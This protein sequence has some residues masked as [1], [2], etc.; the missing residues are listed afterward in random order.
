MTAS[1][2][3]RSRLARLMTSPAVIW[4]V[5]TS[6][7]PLAYTLYDSFRDDRLL[8]PS[9]GFAGLRNY[10]NFVRNPMFAG[11]V[12]HSLI[13]TVGVVATTLALGTALALILD[14]PVKGRSAL[15]LLV[16][17]PFVTMPAVSA[18]VWKNLL[19]NPIAGVFAAAAR[20]LGLTPVDWFGQ[21]PLLSITII[22]AWS[23]LPFATLIVL[24]ALQSLDREQ[25]EAAVLDGAGPLPRFRYLVLPHLA[26]P[27]AVVALVEAI[28]ALA[29]FAEIYVTTSGGPGDAT[30]NLTFLVFSQA[31]LRF[32]IGA[33]SA[34]GVVAVILANLVALALG[35][36]AGRA[37][38]PR[39]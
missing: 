37:V 5:V 13:I 18:L 36:L 23:W 15:R 9:G 21:L 35:R 32:D 26:G 20:G 8:E 10:L 28:F 24:T 19:M 1:T 17:A 12:W 6:L 2:L 22:V 27:M 38:E 14:Q 29:V 16:I 33:A 39:R 30:T 34:G 31:L 7:I 11:A 4:L 3:S 25:L